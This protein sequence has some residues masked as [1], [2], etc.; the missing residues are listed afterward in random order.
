MNEELYLYKGFGGWSIGAIRKENKQSYTMEDGTNIKFSN[1][2]CISK[3]TEEEVKNYRQELVKA[4]GNSAAYGKIKSLREVLRNLNIALNHSEYACVDSTK[5][6]N[7]LDSL[8]AL[9]DV[10]IPE[11]IEISGM[12][13]NV[14]SNGSLELIKK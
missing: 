7:Q 13:F 2:D 10:Y 11:L 6:Q 14:L 1:K 8:T 9:L 5:L 4:I 3:L 12:K